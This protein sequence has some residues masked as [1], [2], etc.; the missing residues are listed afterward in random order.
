[1]KRKVVK[2]VNYK[3]YEIDI[4]GTE[5]QVGEKNTTETILLDGTYFEEEMM[6]QQSKYK[7]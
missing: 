2:T 4:N 6:K 5:R 1:M 7:K 3:E